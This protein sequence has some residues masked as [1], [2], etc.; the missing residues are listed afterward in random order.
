MFGMHFLR[1]IERVKKALYALFEEH[2]KKVHH[3]TWLLFLLI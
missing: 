1:S 2:R 3:L